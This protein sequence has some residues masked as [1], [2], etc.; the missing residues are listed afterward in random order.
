MGGIGEVT[1]EREGLGQRGGTERDV[2]IQT[3]IHVEVWK[4]LL[5]GAH[6]PVKISSK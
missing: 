4:T 3:E 2:G 5:I 6:D 1:V